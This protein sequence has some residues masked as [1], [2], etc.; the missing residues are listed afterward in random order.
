MQRLVQDLI[1][2]SRGYWLIRATAGDVFEVERIHAAR[3]APDTTNPSKVTIDGTVSRTL[4]TGTGPATV[5]TVIEFTGFRDGTLT[6]G[7]DAVTT[8][9]AHQRATRLYAESPAPSQILKNTSNYEL[10][11]TEID[12][13]LDRLPDRAEGEH[14]RVPQ[15]WRRPDVVRVL[16]RRPAN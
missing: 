1:E 13:L 6:L 8:A 16:R 4:S 15:R 2:Y 3:V 11:D 10:S 5:G 12:E 9:A 14:R 7:V